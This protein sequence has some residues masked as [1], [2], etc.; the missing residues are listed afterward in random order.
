MPQRIKGIYYEKSIVINKRL[1]CNKEKKCIAEELGHYFTTIGDIL[2]LEIKSNKKQG[3][4]SK[5]W[6]FKKLVP[7]DELVSAFQSG[8]VNVYELAEY[9]DVTEDFMK[10]SI[11]FYQRKYK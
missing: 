5:N 6:A 7:F 1:E 8:Y 11:L 3:N 4:K 10:E 9:F 2:N